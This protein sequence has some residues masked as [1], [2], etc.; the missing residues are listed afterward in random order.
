MSKTPERK[1]SESGDKSMPTL[2]IAEAAEK[3]AKAVEG[4][5][6][7]DLPEIYLELFPQSIPPT[8]PVASDI[9]HHIRSGLEAEEIVD[10]WHVLFPNDRNVWYDEEESAIRYNEEMVGYTD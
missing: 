10:L 2:T 4:A 7:S 8:P 1:R 9:A 5:K 3:L 6:A